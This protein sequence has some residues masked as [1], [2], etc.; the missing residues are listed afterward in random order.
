MPVQ[1][2]DD[3][4]VRSVFDAVQLEGHFATE[5][6]EAGVGA[7]YCFAVRNAAAPQQAGAPAAAEAAVQ[8]AADIGPSVAL[9]STTATTLTAG[10][11]A[12]TTAAGA[13]TV[14]AS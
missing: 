6:L 14:P 8:A 5:R 7:H 2:N 13:L 1:G 4:G 11:A 12:L 3:R 9:L 10:S